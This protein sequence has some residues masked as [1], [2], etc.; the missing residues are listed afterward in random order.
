MPRCRP[1][2]GIPASRCSQGPASIAFAPHRADLPLPKPFRG[3]ILASKPPGIW[4]MSVKKATLDQILCSRGK[5]RH[6]QI[7]R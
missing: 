5:R 2:S 4:R 6:V 7:V 3:A 1:I